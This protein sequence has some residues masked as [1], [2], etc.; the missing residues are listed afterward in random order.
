MK[1]RISAAL[2]KL[3]EQLVGG[4]KY[5]HFEAVILT[6][7]QEAHKEAGGDESSEEFQKA[8]EAAANGKK[9]IAEAS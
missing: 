9:A 4:Y 6:T 1:D 3:E 7:L 5:L 2:E 8:K